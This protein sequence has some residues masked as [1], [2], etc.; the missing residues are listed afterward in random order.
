MDSAQRDLD[1]IS[2]VPHEF[3][4]PLPAYQVLVRQS[5]QEAEQTLGLVHTE[6]S[7]RNA[8]AS[9]ASA[10]TSVAVNNES[11]ERD[12]TNAESDEEENEEAAEWIDTL[13]FP[14]EHVLD[15]YKSQAMKAMKEPMLD[16]HVHKKLFS[17]YMDNL[18]LQ[19]MQYVSL[20]SD[21]KNVKDEIENTKSKKKELFD[22]R[23]PAYT[24]LTMDKKLKVD[25]K[26][27]L[28]MD[29]IEGRVGKVE[30]KLQLLVTQAT[31][32]N[33]LLVK[34][35]E[36]QNSNPNDNKKGEKDE[37]LS[38]PQADQS[39]DVQAPTANPS[40]PN[41]EAAIKPVKIKRK[42]THSERHEKRKR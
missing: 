28:R 41:T 17:A 12:F 6:Q 25:S 14:V 35:L 7:L 29:Q 2:K 32:T 1:A 18:K 20:H 16:D 31:Q 8:K 39:K 26:I 37:S 9:L 38:K 22:E 42:R 4:H 13:F 30:E 33:K 10:S 34:L 3:T 19:K 15:E 23:L 36:A 21:L 24:V 11:E 5:K 27:E 40:N